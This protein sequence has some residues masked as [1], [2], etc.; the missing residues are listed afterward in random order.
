MNDSQLPGELDSALLV[1][2]EEPLQQSGVVRPLYFYV[3]ILKQPQYTPHEPF[4]QKNDKTR[5]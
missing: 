4:S 1:T 3:A 2:R 5:K